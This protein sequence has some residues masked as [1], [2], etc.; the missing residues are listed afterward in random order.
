MNRCL[1]D[2]GVRVLAVLSLLAVMAV[3]IRPVAGHRAAFHPIR[4]SRKSTVPNLWYGGH[5]RI[6]ARL[7]MRREAD[8]HHDN[9]EDRLEAEFEE[10]LTTIS[11]PASVAF[12]VLPSHDSE[13][14]LSPISFAVAPALPSLRC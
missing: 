2:H 11:P 6:P 8:T 7:S 9:F 1:I 14:S 10:E 5:V 3:P 12:D 4:H 13:S